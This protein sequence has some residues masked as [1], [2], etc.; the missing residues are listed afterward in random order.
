MIF[1]QSRGF[2]H[3]VTRASTNVGLYL[4]NSNNIFIIIY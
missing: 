4:A 1:T 3:R 2:S